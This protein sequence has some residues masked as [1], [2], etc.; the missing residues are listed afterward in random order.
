LYFRSLQYSV[1][2]YCR[3]GGNLR[4]LY[5]EFSYESVGERI[6]KINPMA[7]FLRHNVYYDT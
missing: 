6:L 4:G 2:T 7:D 5:I 3:R 1:A